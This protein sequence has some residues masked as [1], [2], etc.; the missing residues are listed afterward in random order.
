MYKFEELRNQLLHQLKVHKKASLLPSH[1]ETSFFHLVELVAFSLM[2][3]KDNFFGNCMMQMKRIV[4]FNMKAAAGVTADLTHF[5]LHFNP[6]IFLRL[7]LEEMKAEI[8]HQ[9]YHIMLFH[10]KRSNTIKH[11]YSPLVLNTAMDISINQYIKN[12]PSWSMTL[13]KAREVYEVDLPPNCSFEEYADILQDSFNRKNAK[14]N[15]TSSQNCTYHN[16]NNNDNNE[17]KQKFEKSDKDD[18]QLSMHKHL[19]SECHQIWQF[20][21]K[22]LNYENLKDLTKNLANHANR[23]KVPL[24]LLEIITNLNEKPEMKW[25]DILKKMVG[26]LAVPYKKTITRK[27]R[28]QPERHDLRGKLPKHIIKLIIAIDTSGSIS[29]K[30]LQKNLTE[31]FAIVKRHNHEIT[32]IECDAK[33]QNV[34][35][36]RSPKDLKLEVKGRGGTAFSPVF[37]YIDQKKLTN[38][39]LIYFTDGHGER[40]LTTIPKQLKTLWILTGKSGELSLKKPLGIVKKIK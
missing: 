30:D 23:G 7:N 20:S 3:K 24:E 4:N 28:R 37:E 16:Y 17:N 27:D 10:I 5:N 12:M 36:I 2:H 13:E 29:Y 14:G 6:A 25:Q 18:D 34:Y 32:V 9:I 26:T 33:V 35:K 31:V 22:D 11:K 8:K 1:F 39:L 40:E 38:H 21:N 19:Q 15:S